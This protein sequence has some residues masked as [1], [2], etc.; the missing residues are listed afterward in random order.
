M[1]QMM[2]NIGQSTGL[3]GKLPGMK[4]LGNIK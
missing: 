2:G 3:L 1:R 4:Q